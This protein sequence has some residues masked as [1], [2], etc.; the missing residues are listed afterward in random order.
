VEIT[1]QNCGANCFESKKG[2]TMNN[3]IDN[4]EKTQEFFNPILLSI[5]NLAKSLLND[6]Y[7]IS[8][9]SYKE[10]RIVLELF[11]F[12]FEWVHHANAIDGRFY[13]PKD[14]KSDDYLYEDIYVDI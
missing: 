5:E 4:V 13:L 12:D 9:K 14:Q 3:D 6:E 7:G 10:L 1:Y 2:K 8:E 11:E